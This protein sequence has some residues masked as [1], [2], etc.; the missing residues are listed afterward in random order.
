MVRL[1]LLLIFP[2]TILL[3][4]CQSTVSEEATKPLLFELVS[5]ETSG[6][7]FLNE[8]QNRAGLNIMTYRNYYNGGGVAIGDINNDNLSDIYF[9]SNLGPNK[10]FLNKGNWEFEDIS[11][12][13]GVSGSKAWSTGVVMADVNADGLLDIYVCNSGG[14]DGDN[15]ENELFINNGDL[16]FTERAADFGLNDSGLTTHASFFDYDLDGD[17]DCYILNN[18]FKSID[19][20]Q[21]FTIPRDK[22]EEGGDKLLR[23]DN[24]KFVD[25]SDEAGIYGSW[26]GFGLGV[27]VGDIDGDMFPDM[28]ISNDFWERDYLYINNQDGTFRE[29]LIERTDLISA[30]SM[31]SDIADVNN[32]GHVEIFTTE[33]LPGDN[34]RLKTMTKFEET[35]IKE[36]KVRSSY[37]YQ[38]MQNSFQV[39]DGLGNFKDMSF[40]SGLAATD[41]S[42]GALMFDMDNDGWKDIFVSNGIY[43]DIT[44]MDFV[45]FASDNENIR[46]IV[47]EKGKFEFSDLEE[48]L[49]ST[50]IKNYA[51]VNTRN[52]LFEDKA[53]ELGLGEPSFSNG[54]AYG[55]LDN[56]G[57]LDLVVNNLNMPSFIYRNLTSEQGRN[58]YIQFKFKGAE[59]NPF[60]IGSRVEIFKDGKKQVQQNFQARGFESSTEPV[61]TFGIGQ[62]ERLDSVIVTWGN[63]DRE[64]LK[65]VAANT[66]ITLDANNA[67][68]GDL[69]GPER[70]AED[71][72]FA[73]VTENVLKG[74][75]DH[76]ENSF[77]DFDVER[78]IPR[79]V[80][81]EGPKIL[82]GDLSGDGLQDFVLLGAHG[83]EDK[84]FVQSENGKFEQIKIPNVEKD[85]AFESTCGVIVDIDADGDND[86]VIGSG[87]NQLEKGARYSFARYYRNDG[88][89]RFKNVQSLGPTAVGNFSVIAAN[90]IDKDGD[91][92][93]FFGGRIVPGNYGLIPRSFLFRNDEDDEWTNI[94][95]DQLSGA[96][97]VTDAV[98][99]DYNSD[100]FDDLVVVGDWMSLKIYPNSEG[101][102]GNPST[103]PN[104][105]G[106]WTSIEVADVNNDG[107]DDYILG[108]WGLNTKFKTSKDRPLSM[109]VKDFDSNGK[110]DII[111]N[112]YPPEE[113]T[114]FPFASKMDLTAQMPALKKSAFTYHEF[115][116]MTYETLF[117]EEQRRGALEYKTN[118]L[119]SAVLINNNQKFK[120]IGLPMEAQISPVF[121]IE[122]GDWDGDGNV[123]LFLGGNFYHL[124]PEVGRH[125]GNK[126]VFLIGDGAGGFKPLPQRETGIRIDGEVRD[127]VSI[128]SN[129]GNTYLLI[130]R[131]N[132]PA[133]VL[134]R[135]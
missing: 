120:L 81:T 8:V 51:F 56:D 44:S 67:R 22:R 31:G 119:Q 20:V 105:S 17:L 38:L 82:S 59:G 4:S 135:K 132:L 42:W 27:S 116:G 110:S 57:D 78:L 73:D 61:L 12:N 112:W 84:V 70:L 52:G 30:S 134:Q 10:L 18:S 37:H 129:D 76:K 92:D 33:M 107:M 45:D 66:L 13:A 99:S 24:G 85:S 101:N 86:I 48:Y 94:G 75:Y 102:L 96:G 1:L 104:S 125:D 65:N 36:L 50:P 19:R 91:I 100:G 71:T 98:W 63:G 43:H 87:G 54:A 32:D 28:Y 114:P 68:G 79:A 25:V 53:L 62:A 29:E 72:L 106:W 97:M 40:M 89:G 49:P 15:K 121:G 133:I 122:A 16:T 74:N 111:I 90:D 128:Q 95:P 103:L 14:I 7:D 26:I 2:I 109:Y 118:Y 6:I 3:F 115:A 124:K 35:N 39:N 80:S 64:V 41:W 11:K 69:Q 5:A 83:D 55:D 130:A 23:N 108:N 126:G 127:V 9:T 93:L 46:K 117:V 113:N 123:D 58:N 34:Y 77:N 60:G 47:E 131:N 88:E 21:Q